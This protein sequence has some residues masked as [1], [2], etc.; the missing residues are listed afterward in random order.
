LRSPVELTAQS[1]TLRCDAKQAEKR[2]SDFDELMSSISN[3]YL[4]DYFPRPF[5]KGTQPRYLETPDEES[6]PVISTLAIQNLSIDVAACRSISREDF[7][8]LPDDRKLKKSDILLTVDGG[9]SIGKPCLFTLDGDYTVDS[10]IVILRPSNVEPEV[11]VY[12][13]ASPLGQTQFQRAESGASGQ[14]AVT[15][16]DIRRF[17]FPK[18]SEEGMRTLSQ[19]L[20]QTLKS[21]A[22]EMERLNGMQRKAWA[23]FN[24]ALIDTAER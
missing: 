14:T 18:V 12:L 20:H 7:D 5:I 10:H 8:A 1:H 15:E 22:Q 19:N 21:I 23:S 3:V 6:V 4:G 16:D 2:F 9:T 13:L 24:S 11:I 17:R